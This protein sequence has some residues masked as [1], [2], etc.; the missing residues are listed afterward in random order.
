M[1]SITGT[2]EEVFAEMLRRVET[3]IATLPA[4]DVTRSFVHALDEV[5]PDSVDLLLGRGVVDALG[6]VTKA[7]AVD[8]V[9][10]G[11]VSIREGP[12]SDVLLVGPD[13]IGALDGSVRP[14]LGMVGSA[15]EY[16][17]YADR[18]AESEPLDLDACGRSE[19]LDA[20]A[21]MVGDDAARRAALETQRDVRARLDPIALLVWA[22]A[23]AN[24]RGKDVADAVEALGLATRRTANRRIER[25]RQEGLI[26]TDT[27][28]TDSPGRPDR[29]LLPTVDV[30]SEEPLP[31]M[32][33]A[34]LTN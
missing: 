19:L 21:E 20:T 25:F 4:R 8:H 10:A 27:L 26:E 17:R 9:D 5:E 34:E 1:D 29:R 7:R 31:K 14:A 16:D 22:G 23:E 13:A 32:L 33:F 3:P 12:V 6:W 18:F 2:T 30:T 24:A 15:D 11:R 28:A